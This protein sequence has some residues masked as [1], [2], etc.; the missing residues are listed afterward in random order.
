M[1]RVDQML[2]SWG[3]KVDDNERT[4]RL[5]DLTLVSVL[6]DAGAGP[7]WKYRSSSKPGS[8]PYRRSEGLAVASFEMFECGLFSGDD[9]QPFQ[10]DKVGL[11]DLSVDAVRTAM[12]VSEQN[13]LDGLEGRTDVLLR[14]AHALDNTRYF[15][16]NGRPGNMLGKSSQLSYPFHRP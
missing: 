4:R 5:I 6:L 1:P 2:K 16:S 3:A 12:Q 8:P 11:R 9:R 14:L 13:P 10:V 15:G 7:E